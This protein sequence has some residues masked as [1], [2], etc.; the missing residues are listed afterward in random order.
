MWWYAEEEQ[1]ASSPQWRL[2][3]EGAR[4]AVIES[5]GDV[6][7]IAAEGGCG[8]HSSYNLWKAFPGVEKR[9][10][11]RGIPE[12]FI[13][14]L[15]RAGGASGHNETIMRFDYDSDTLCVDVEVYKYVALQM[16]RDEGVDVLLNTMAVDAVMDGERVDCIITES[17]EGCEAVRGNVFI[18]ATGYGDLCARAGAD[19]T[20]S[21]D[22]MVANSMG[23]AGIDIDKYY[24][25]LRDNGALI[26]YGRGPRSGRANQIIRVDGNWKS[27]SPELDQQVRLLGMHTVTTTLHLPDF[28]CVFSSSLI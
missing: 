10:V 16:L 25:F 7:G 20:E 11:V 3:E 14:R 13:Q 9:Q 23:I 5:K 22:Y 18:D 24:S 2:P 6:R 19:Y 4:T 1:G 26:E 15:T 17:H 12:E 21:N 27:I 28:Y 8:L